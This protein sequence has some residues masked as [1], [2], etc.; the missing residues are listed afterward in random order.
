[1]MNCFLLLV[2]KILFS[3]FLAPGTQLLSTS[4]ERLLLPILESGDATPPCTKSATKCLWQTHKPLGYAELFPPAGHKG[5][6]LQDAQDLVCLI[7]P[8]SNNDLEKL[9]K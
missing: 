6:T 7:Y 9:A 1:M 5:G 3:G 2:T 4:L 8:L